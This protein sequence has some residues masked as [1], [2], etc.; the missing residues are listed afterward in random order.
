ME[1]IMYQKI[2]CKLQPIMYWIKLKFQEETSKV[3][4]VYGAEPWA[5]W[6]I[7]NTWKVVKCG[8]EKART[9]SVGQ[10]LWKMNKQNEG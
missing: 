6:Y 3:L 7:W 5:L 9:R 2:T 4:H 1:T 8:A 10:T